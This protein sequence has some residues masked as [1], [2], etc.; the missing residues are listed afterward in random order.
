MGRGGDKVAAEWVAKHGGSTLETIMSG[1]GVA[2]PAWDTS[3]PAVVSAWRDASAQFA[4][5]AR[6]NVRVLQGDAVRMDS[7]WAQVEF[8]A[9]KANTNVTSITAINPS[10]GVSS[11]IWRR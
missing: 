7:V 9:L 3:N 11:V 2:L 1:R 4:Q 8:P 10:T 6:G 5:G